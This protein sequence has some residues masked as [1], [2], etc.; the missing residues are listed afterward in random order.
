M[1][2][3]H[4]D[5]NMAEVRSDFQHLLGGNAHTLAQSTHVNN[6]RVRHDAEFKARVGRQRFTVDYF[7]AGRSFPEDPVLFPYLFT[8][9]P[10]FTCGVVNREG[11]SNLYIGNATA[12]VLRFITSTD[13]DKYVGAY[14]GYYV[15]VRDINDQPV[16]NPMKLTFCLT[17]EGVI[18]P[19]PLVSTVA[20]GTSV[21]S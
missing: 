16:Q 17:F 18:L 3:Y 5:H 14:M 8:E 15:D 6:Q 13:G 19:I 10:T 12:F 4:D 1:E 7:G 20:G 9:E 2:T 21:Q 11:I